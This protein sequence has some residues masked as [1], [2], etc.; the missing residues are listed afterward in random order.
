MLSDVAPEG[1][2]AQG[3]GVRPVAKDRPEP[4]DRSVPT[5]RPVP[6]VMTWSSGRQ[7]L[8]LEFSGAETDG[9]LL[10]DGV[11][12]LTL[13]AADWLGLRDAISRLLAFE[14]AKP[15]GKP[16]A[17]RPPRQGA[18]WS[19]ADDRQLAALFEMGRLPE[20]I[21]FELDRSRGAIVSRLE[22]LGLVE[23]G[24]L[25]P[26]FAAAQKQWSSERA[27]APDEG[28][29]SHPDD[30]GPCNDARPDRDQR[31]DDW[32]TAVQPRDV[33]TA[34]RTEGSMPISRGEEKHMP[35]P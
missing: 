5:E 17:G 28:P 32:A 6:K 9:R 26:N 19:E 31:E 23:R 1:E 20:T 10:V 35:G 21:G 4:K 14:K 3:G 27:T 2:G 7:V 25:R 33:G 16:V 15:T 29:P 13:P 30:P 18:A 22:R 34:D 11:A 24:V 12:Y 8:K